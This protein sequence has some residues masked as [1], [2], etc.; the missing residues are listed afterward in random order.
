M[1]GEEPFKNIS[2]K[3]ALFY[4]PEKAYTAVQVTCKVN[5]DAIVMN[6]GWQRWVAPSTSTSI[7]NIFGREY[8]Y[9][10]IRGY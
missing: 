1:M 5:S 10:V 9:T 6:R 3:D 8:S 7:N 4:N 2:G